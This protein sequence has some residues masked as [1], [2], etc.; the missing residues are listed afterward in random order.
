MKIILLTPD[1]HY[2]TGIV[3]RLKYEHP[4]AEIIKVIDP[5]EALNAIPKNEPCIVITE[6]YSLH[7]EGET[8]ISGVEKLVVDMKKKNPNSKSILYAID[9]LDINQNLFNVAILALEKNAYEL[10][11]KKIK[12]YSNV[13]SKKKVTL[14]DLKRKGVSLIGTG[15]YCSLCQGLCGNS[16]HTEKNW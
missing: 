11:L 1:Q 4:L 7:T 10:L 5:N 16:N 8:K 6:S 14:N 2:W 15:T 12:E 13:T 9:F 3:D